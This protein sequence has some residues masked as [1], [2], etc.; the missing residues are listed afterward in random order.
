MQYNEESAKRPASSARWQ[1]MH[2]PAFLYEAPQR[3]VPQSVPNLES[4]AAGS[5]GGCGATF[6]AHGSLGLSMRHDGGGGGCDFIAG[7]RSPGD[8]P[9]RVALDGGQEVDLQSQMMAAD[10][11]RNVAQ[12]S[13]QQAQVDLHSQLMAADVWRNAAQTSVQQAQHQ[14]MA[15]VA[16]DA[17]SQ[18]VQL[19]QQLPQADHVEATLQLLQAVT[20]QLGPLEGDFLQQTIQEITKRLP[21]EAQGCQQS[22]ALTGAQAA[23]T[24]GWG[25]PVS[26]EAVPNCWSGWGHQPMSPGPMASAPQQCADDAFLVDP[27]IEELNQYIRQQA[28]EYIEGQAEWSRQ[29]AEVRGEC[30]RE[31][32]K[33]K[34]GK[35]EVEHQARQ[36]ILRLTHR[37]RDLGAKDEGPQGDQDS[38]QHQVGAWAAGVSMDEHQQLQRKHAAAE[39]R[40]EQLEQYLKDQSAK[41]LL[42]GDLQQMKEKDAEAEKLRQVVVS[43]SMELQQANIELQA[44]RAQ[45]Q[46]TVGFWEQGV[47]RLLA[48]TEHQ[49]GQLSGEERCENGLF[50]R[51][52]TKLSLTLSQEK[53]GGDM[54]SLSRLLKDA[55]SQSA[56]DGGAAA[57]RNGR[58]HGLKKS[59]RK[60]KSDD[61]S[62]QQVAEAKAEE[63]PAKVAAAANAT[64]A[65]GPTSVA[66][67]PKA[68]PEAAPCA[69]EANPEERSG[70]S[71]SGARVEAGLASTTALP[72]PSPLSD[73]DASSR[74]SSPGRGSTLLV[75]RNGMR[76]G[77]CEGGGAGP[78]GGAGAG[79]AHVLSQFATELRQ[80][81][82][83]GQQSQPKLGGDAAADAAPQH[84]AASASKGGMSRSSSPGGS[85]TSSLQCAA[86][87]SS[88]HLQTL[89]SLSRAKRGVA[90]HI[91]EAEKTL[92]GLERHLKGTCEDL[93]GQAELEVKGFDAEGGSGSDADDGD[94]AAAIDDEARR[95]LPLLV[96]AQ[97]LSMLSLRR[98][99]RRSSDL[100]GQ[101]VQLPQ[102]LKTVFDLT[103]QLAVEVNNLVPSSLLHQA[104]ARASGSRL[105]EQ[106][107][108][109]H[110]QLLQR[111]LD[112]VSSQVAELQ[113]QQRACTIGG[114]RCVAPLSPVSLGGLQT[115]V[116][117]EG[118]GADA[119]E[120]GVR[121]TASAPSAAACAGSQSPEDRVIALEQE[122]VDLHLA[123]Y[124]ERAQCLA[125][126]QQSA[127]AGFEQAAAAAAAQAPRPLPPA[128]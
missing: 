119:A 23:A 115:P 112:A 94:C 31:V 82:A 99:Q 59:P 47:R 80:L 22:P 127:A 24:S 15:E 75:G 5:A 16:A 84:H 10:A 1:D 52:A 38:Q 79:I 110:V 66:A 74:T 46:Q 120:E 32:E 41:Q 101:F 8:S 21:A 27:R 13:V 33:A 9:R 60:G 45:F 73:S 44:L 118:A 67:T 34:R 87:A 122:V 86:G 19:E 70:G 6:A 121:S 113:G 123:R 109:F 54:S 114:Q 100:L 95:R 126:L 48:T 28:Q 14:Q 102:K 89:E 11:W 30:M 111:Q 71:S 98:A 49:L 72:S 105:L 57:G 96:E 125:L 61:L 62:T 53:K 56:P 85:S 97:T 4:F 7:G 37:L 124:T 12:T 91:I 92:R 20:S 25:T 68:P 116:A 58:G 43:S 51:T 83:T 26:A 81:L 117:V 77:C 3:M 128:S 69:V 55:L 42:S 64:Q 88:G 17:E 39:E 108:A 50:G 2:A 78:G 104:E 65:A 40:V 18:H 107:H 76:A 35:E 90:Q 103:K 93:L 29:I 106:R 63:D 36:E